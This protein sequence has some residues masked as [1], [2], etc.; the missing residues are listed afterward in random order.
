MTYQHP[1]RVN[2][3]DEL[4]KILERRAKAEAE[5]YRL[6]DRGRW[7]MCIPVQANDSDIL[8][9]ESLEDISHLAREIVRLNNLMKKVCSVVT[10]SWGDDEDGFEDDEP[11]AR[12]FAILE[13]W[14]PESK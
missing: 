9:T 14:L 13:E 8:L 6:C 2:A 10:S 12:L 4:S 3:V 5:V 11:Q 1:V 7:Q